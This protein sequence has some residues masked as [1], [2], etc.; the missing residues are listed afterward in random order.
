MLQPDSPEWSESLIVLGRGI[1]SWSQRYKTRTH[2][3]VGIGKANG[4]LRLYPLFAYEDA[5][6]FDVVQVAIRDEHPERHRPESRK[7][8][9]NSVSVIDHEGDKREQYKILKSLCQA[10]EFLHGEAWRNQTIGV[11]RPVKPHFWITKTR[12][13]MV[14]YRCNAPDC[15]GH[16]NEVLE[17]VKVDKV[18]RRWRPKVKE[19]EKFITRLEKRKLYFVMGT[20]RN[21]PHRWMLIAIHLT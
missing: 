5:K 19:L 16:L 9:P 8:Y 12:K 20:H 10:G 1:N 14:R 3:I 7:I 13:F 6:K 21:Y 11:I 4:L 17:V 18:G 2:C 15:K